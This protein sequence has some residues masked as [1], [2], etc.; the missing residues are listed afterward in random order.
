M[1]SEL[2]DRL[3][4]R[5]TDAGFSM[6]SL[7]VAAGLNETYVRDVLAGRGKPSVDR[8][9][10]IA[11]VL[12]TTVAD[13]MGEEEQ[14]LRSVPLMGFVGAGAEVHPEFE[15]VPPEGLEQITVPFPLPGDMIAFKVKGDSMLPQFRDG[16]V[17]IVFREQR[18]SLESFYG[19]EAVV[20]TNDGRRFIKTIL[21]GNRGVTLS[22][23]NATPIENVHLAWVG[24]IF[25]FFPPS[26]M[27]RV[28]RQGGIQGRLKLSA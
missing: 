15:Q 26:A 25:T 5:M 9:A 14:G 18:R 2:T 24:E 1:N 4:A 22:S 21:R 13:L 23:W 7:S 19:E 16:T 28:E 20:R 10:R 6:K 11:Q 8:L 3:R 17:I 27:R 12:G